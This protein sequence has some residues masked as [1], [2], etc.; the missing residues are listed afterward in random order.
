M[1]VNLND[2][3]EIGEATFRWKKEKM[4]KNYFF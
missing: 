1:S 4:M 2:H 3:P